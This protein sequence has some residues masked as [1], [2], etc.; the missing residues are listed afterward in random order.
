MT[1]HFNA[2][3]LIASELS[4]MSMSDFVYKFAN[5]NKTIETGKTEV[6][7]F[8]DTELMTH[9]DADEQ[10]RNMKESAQLKVPKFI[11]KDVVGEFGTDSDVA[12]ISFRISIN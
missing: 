12:S 8:Y 4:S 6:Y 3:K 11:C 10:H 7:T 9:E 2:L 1:I 5:C